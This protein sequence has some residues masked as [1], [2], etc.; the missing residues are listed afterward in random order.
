VGRRMQDRIEVTKGLPAQ[1][2]V[3]S[4]GGVFLAD[5]DTVRVVPA[6]AS[7]A[8]SAAPS[9]VQASAPGKAQP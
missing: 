7:S 6:A 5:G 8:A 3:V 1:A 4:S 2:E 9:P